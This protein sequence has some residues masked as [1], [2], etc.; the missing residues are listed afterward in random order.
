M[1]AVT[2][3]YVRESSPELPYF[4][5]LHYEDFCRQLDHFQSQ[6]TLIGQQ[7]FLDLLR[8]KKTPAPQA[9]VLTFDDGFADHYHYVFPELV[10]RGLWAA[11]FVTTGIY[12]TGQ[13]LDVH[14]IHYLL[15]RYGGSVLMDYLNRILTRDMLSAENFEE[16]QRATYRQDN[17]DATTMVKRILN[18][19][20]SYEWRH[21]VIDDLMKKLYDE[22]RLCQDLYATADQIRE[23]HRAGMLIGSH[24]VSHALLSRLS[25]NE[26]RREI[27]DSFTFVQDNLTLGGPRLFCY[28][29]GWPHSFTPDTE[30]ILDETGCLG[31]FTVEFRDI[32]REDLKRRPQALPRYDCNLFPHGRAR[33]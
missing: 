4:R 20:I 32:S 22:D 26:Q 19:Y 33:L 28:P 3:H 18:Y 16:I 10:K 30:I 29:Y 9:M 8:E 13:A 7:E 11:F 23:M 14:R 27:L 24:T 25:V 21:F 12:Q 5:Y 15:G 2:Y 17:D 6:H 31:S 1:K